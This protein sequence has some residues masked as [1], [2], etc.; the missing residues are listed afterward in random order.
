MEH[1]KQSSK[2]ATEEKKIMKY[3][4]WFVAITFALLMSAAVVGAV[5]RKFFAPQ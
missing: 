5:Y 2:E 4:R 3:I 1:Q